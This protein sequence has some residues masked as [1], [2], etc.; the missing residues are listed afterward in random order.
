M[1]VGRQEVA[2]DPC[3]AHFIGYLENERNASEHTVQGY[4][5]DIAQ[6]ATFRWG[7]QASVP[8]PWGDT[9]RFAARRFLVEFQRAGRGASTTGRKL[10]SLKT[11]H[12]F[13]IR[14][15]YIAQN[16]FSGLRAPKKPR[17]LPNVLSVAEVKRL[18]E[19]PGRTLGKARRDGSPDADQEY[20]AAR[21]TAILETLYSTGGRVGEISLMDEKDLDLISGIVTVKGK[22]KKERLCPLGTPACRA[23]KALLALSEGRW[24]GGGRGQIRP[25]FRNLRDGGRLRPRSIERLMKRC[26]ADANL[27]AEF[28]PHTLRHSF[29]THMLD[30]GADLRSVQELLGHASLSTTQI[31]THISVEHLRRVYEEAHPRA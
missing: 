30:A 15:E 21:D 22:G 14:E 25:V 1:P 20:T 5:S 24:S 3:V 18:I 26:L 23:L 2:R 28:S 11:F 13:L 10:S 31:Y 29:A 17:L 6:F 19:V 16:P 4:V 27:S 8:C 9:D 7:E 12:R